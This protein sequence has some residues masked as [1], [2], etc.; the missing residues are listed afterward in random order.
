MIYEKN[1]VLIFERFD[2]SWPR[3]SHLDL[4]LLVVVGLD[5]KYTGE[6]H[7]VR[8]HCWHFVVWCL[9][10]CHQPLLLVYAPKVEIS[11]RKSIQQLRCI[12][13]RPD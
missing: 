3:L 11:Q 1:K 10:G 5:S 12:H 9:D 6:L 13:A 8:P 2:S 7:C 4:A